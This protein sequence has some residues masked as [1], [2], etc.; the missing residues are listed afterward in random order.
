M[1][2]RQNYY[3]NKQHTRVVF[4][5]LKWSC[6]LQS[7][8]PQSP[9]A[10]KAYLDLEVAPDR[11]ATPCCILPVLTL[12]DTDG[13][14]TSGVANTL[15][16]TDTYDS[17]Y[18]YVRG[19]EWYVDGQEISSVWTADLSDGTYK[20]YK[21][22]ADTSDE[23]NGML[24][25]RKNLS[26]GESVALQYRGVFNDT[27]T[28]SNIVVTSDIIVL[29]CLEA[30]DEEV[31]MDVSP[32]VITYDPLKDQRLL[33]DYLV[34]LG[35]SASYEDDGQTYLRT[36]TVTILQGTEVLEGVPDGYTL[37]FFYRGTDTE[38]T[39]D[40]AL[41]VSI[42]GMTITFDLRCMDDTEIEV[43]LTN[44]DTGVVLCRCSLDLVY[45]PTEVTVEPQSRADLTYSQDTYYNE[46]IVKTAKGVVEYPELYF[47]I[48]WQTMAVGEDTTGASDEETTVGYGATLELPVDDIGM[49][50]STSDTA[51]FWS[52]ITL[53]GRAACTYL[54]D[55]NDA[56]LVDSDGNYLIG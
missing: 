49:D 5:P 43:R 27:R 28:G 31:S 20:D 35:E 17:S 50:K 37:G 40:E 56:V 9:V 42:S 45:Q 48:T 1:A 51:Q 15:L 19:H 12:Y 3:S 47:N 23:E 18:D 26:A 32:S 36:A 10:Q 33:Y 11:A 25:V 39:T 52:K 22:I 30:G 2:N 53:E 24:I 29:E 55:D 46:A 34:G 13:V 54:T 8:E 6:V 14:M 7:T 16:A 38:L 41:V 44:D 21:I 4:T